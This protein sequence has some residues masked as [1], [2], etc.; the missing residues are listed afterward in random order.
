MMH[1]IGQGLF[2][3]LI[4]LGLLLFRLSAGNGFHVVSRVFPKS[5]QRWLYGQKPPS[6]EKTR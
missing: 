4:V 2:I 3:F 1:T 6:A 5:W